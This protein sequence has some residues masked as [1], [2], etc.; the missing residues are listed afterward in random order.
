MEPNSQQG[1]TSINQLPSGPQMGNGFENPP[2]N[3]NM[4]N[5]STMNNIVLTKTDTI[6]ESNSQMQNPMQNPMQTQQQ[7]TQIQSQGQ[8]M[9]MQG[10]TQANYNELIN[11]LQQASSQGATG[12]PTR[13]MPMNPSDNANDIEV[14]PNFVPPPP[15]HEDYINNMQTPE[16]LIMQNNN[17]Q[18]QI[19][20]L[21]AFYGEFQL[22][23]LIAI[24]YFLFQLIN[25]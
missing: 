15:S 24:L 2:Q 11:Q 7:Q 18:R 12:L 19:D 13:D 1:I 25:I 5:S 9:E 10:Q 23:I 8:N 21:D 6:G 20:N 22:P 14:K 16:N 17:A 3:A 4:M